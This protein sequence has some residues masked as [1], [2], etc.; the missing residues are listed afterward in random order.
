MKNLM[1]KTRGNISSRFYSHYEVSASELLQNL[2]ELLSGQCY[3]QIQASNHILCCPSR[4]WTQEKKQLLVD[5][6]QA[7]CLGHVLPIKI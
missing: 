2:E 3:Q 4:K 7:V 6:A 1:M 5:I